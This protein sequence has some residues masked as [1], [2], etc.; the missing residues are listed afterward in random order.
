MN[1]AVYAVDCYIDECR[2]SI[3]LQCLA[4]ESELFLVPNFKAKHYFRLRFRYNVHYLFLNLYSIFRNILQRFHI[5]RSINDFVH[6]CDPI[7]YRQKD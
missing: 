2:V 1:V 6:Y 7:F 3:V 4:P 5:R